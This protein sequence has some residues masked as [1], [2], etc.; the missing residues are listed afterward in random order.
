MRKLAPGISITF[1]LLAACSEEPKALSKDLGGDPRRMTLQTVQRLQEKHGNQ[2]YRVTLRV[3]PAG[4]LESCELAKVDEHAK[5]LLCA[6]IRRWK[7]TD[8]ECGQEFVVE[9]GHGYLK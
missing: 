6:S 3:S 2:S 9:F 1:A 8:Q 5:D 7:F 4:A